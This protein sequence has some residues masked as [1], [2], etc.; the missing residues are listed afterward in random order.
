MKTL[1]VIDS[2]I[3][4]KLNPDSYK[5]SISTFKINDTN[6]T[7]INRIVLNQHNYCK[8]LS[9]SRYEVPYLNTMLL[10][11]QLTVSK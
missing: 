5:H 10:L 7:Q 9:L 4:A 2:F 11:P 6:D 3:L 1:D 8:Y